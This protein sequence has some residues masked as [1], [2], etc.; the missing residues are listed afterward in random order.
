MSADVYSELTG[1]VIG[2]AL[3]AHSIWESGRTMGIMALSLDTSRQFRSTTELSELVEAIFAAPSSESEPDWLEWK[4][5][6]DLSERRWHARIAKIIAG[7]ANRDPMA[8]K[9]S[10]GGCAYLVIGVEPGNVTGIKTVDNADLDAGVSRFIGT[11]A[12]WNSQFIECDTKHVLVVTVEPP[13]FG[14]RIV[15]MLAAYQPQESAKNVCRKGD[16]YIRRPG[17]TDLAT[18][19]DFDMLL[20]RH[21]S[22]SEHVDGI[23]VQALEAVTAVPVKWD[24]DDLAA[25]RERQERDLLAQLH[26]K[27]TFSIGTSIG[28]DMVVRRDRRSADDFG[29]EVATYLS[30]MEFVLPRLAR[31]WAV[32]GHE[33]GV[34]LALINNTQHNFAAVRVEVTIDGDVWAYRNVED[35]RP[36]LPS[37]P[38]LW[39]TDQSWDSLVNST[40][41]IL[42]DLYGPEID[43][44]APTRIVFHDVDLRPNER[45]IL[46]P[47]HIVTDIALAGT[48]LAAKWTATSSSANGV[49]SGEVT[50]AVSPNIV[51]PLK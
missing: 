28:T 43:N 25:W 20:Q 42:P 23:N 47:I 44:S 9:Q 27:T 26:K 35:A 8:S 5:G 15:A 22:G 34:R 39:N 17:R 41:T 12:R 38:R 49:V 1:A 14:D 30:K 16:V 33:A 10:A 4:R 36:E 7:F 11:A 40:E 37:L 46:D 29:N 19:E 32:E 24:S 6:V 45:V 50:V 2:S 13:A 21:G 48:T 3:E 51:A 18:Q 31:A